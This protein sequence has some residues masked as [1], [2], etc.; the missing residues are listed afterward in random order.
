MRIRNFLP[1]LGVF[2]LTTTVSATGILVPKEE[3]LAPL[4]IKYH[5]VNVTIREQV[6]QTSVEQVFHNST[7]RSLEATFIFPLPEGASLSEFAIMI[8]VKRVAGELVEKE[9]AA[10][11]Y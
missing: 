6:A 3:G 8:N 9:E 10:M 7:P 5:R 4:A 2:L 1:I 11:I